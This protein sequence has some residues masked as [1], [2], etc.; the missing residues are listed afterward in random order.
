LALVLVF[1]LVEETKRRSLE[2]LDHIF[3]VSKRDFMRFQMTEIL[4]WF[5]GKTF[6]RNR[7]KRPQLYK[8]LIW[9]SY[10][11]EG[12]TRSRIMDELDG[13]ETVRSY[14]VAQSPWS[15]G[16]PSHI[17]FAMSPITPVSTDEIGLVGRNP[18]AVEI[19]DSRPMASSESPL[20]SHPPSYQNEEGPN[21]PTDSPEVQY[22]DVKYDYR[23]Q[24]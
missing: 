9:G 3:A 19:G 1:L 18:N 12:D 5:L 4:P 21:T 15:E 7:T 6:L 22:D 20:G 2:D 10:G 23:K 16:G 24:E 11:G 13:V 14:S 17:A 8:D